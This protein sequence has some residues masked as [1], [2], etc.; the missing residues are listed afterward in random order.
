MR[1]DFFE[2][3]LNY[4]GL[5]EVIQAHQVLLLPMTEAE[6]Q[7]AI[8]APAKIAKYKFEPGLLPILMQ[9][10]RS[11]QNILPLLEFALAQL[12]QRR[13]GLMLTLVAYRELGGVMGA[14][15][16][17][18]QEIFASIRPTDRAWAQRI[19]LQL[20]RIGEGEKDTRKRQPKAEIL[21]LASGPEQ[22]ALQRALE[23]LVQGRLLVTDSDDGTDWVDLAHESLMTGW[24]QFV[25][26]RQANRD[27]RRLIQR[28]VDADRTWKVI[29][30][31]RS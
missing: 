12:W 17:Q 27:Q 19:C 5:G 16:Q 14:L 23:K 20:V 8:E 3:C 28:I 29:A 2:H 13:Q 1:A 7:D 15:N 22:R 24:E 6:L 26:W 4:R 21:G 30:Q 31:I 11:E 9:E 10:V 25:G 18:A